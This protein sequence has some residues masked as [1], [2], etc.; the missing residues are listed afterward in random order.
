MG[1][2]GGPVV[3][4]QDCSEEPMSRISALSIGGLVAVAVVGHIWLFSA[5]MS[6]QSA[7]AGEDRNANQLV[8]IMLRESD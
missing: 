3:V 2:K 8:T 4:P 7:S 6:P 1:E 5:Q